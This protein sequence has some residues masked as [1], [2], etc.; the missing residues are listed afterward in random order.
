MC[1]RSF[2]PLL[3][4][5]LAE[6]LAFDFTAEPVPKFYED[7]RM[8]DPLD[9]VLSTCSALL[10]VVKAND[11]DNTMVVQFSH[12]SVKEYLMSARFAEKHDSISQYFHFSLIPAHTL[13]A[14]AC[15]GVLFR[16]DKSITR[17]RLW[18][19]PLF[20]YAAR[21]WFMHARFEG[22]P[23]SVEEGMKQLFDAS[24]PHLAV[25]VW[26]ADPIHPWDSNDTFTPWTLPKGNALHYAAF[27]GLHDIVRLL[28]IE[29]LGDVD[30]RDVNK[31]TPLHL[32]SWEGHTEVARLLIDRGANIT[33]RDKHKSTPLHLASERGHME[34]AQLL[35]GRGAAMTVQDRLGSTPL[36]LALMFHHTE[37][38]Q[39]LVERGADA[40]ARDNH[41]STPLH[42]V[43]MKG[44]MKFAQLLIGCGADV[45]ARDKD[46]MTPLHQAVIWGHVKISQFL[47]D[48]GADA[49]ARCMDGS[50]MVHLALASRGVNL[51]FILFLVEHGVDVTAQD[52]D[53]VTPLHRAAVWGPVEIAQLLVERG[54]DVTAQD[55]DGSTPLHQ[56]SQWGYIEIARFLVESGAD[57]TF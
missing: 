36:H 26:V 33:A 41:L 54:A 43:S 35:V 4:E 30:T 5:E 14:E 40:T 55:K 9:A 24:N 50:T 51:E 16:L 20:Q 37:L 31:S 48:H 53:G 22:V 38:A 2:R 13:V 23:Q 3:V 49:T 39:F 25:W 15:L 45:T 44:D 6:F 7:W 32:A 1:R 47:V 57:V 27:C 17:D 52:K 42:Q 21:Y 28:L 10:A 34:L 56:A 29:D 11:Y 46:G 8:E 19:F 18:K 12:F